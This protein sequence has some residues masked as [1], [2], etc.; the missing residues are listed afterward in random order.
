MDYKTKA[1]RRLKALRD[2]T[3]PQGKNMI[4]FYRNKS[5]IQPDL[6]GYL[7]EGKFYELRKLFEKFI[8]ADPIFREVIGDEDD[9]ETWMKKS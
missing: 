3:K 9:R 8:A 7:L 6:I 2:Q 4:E 1:L 5:A